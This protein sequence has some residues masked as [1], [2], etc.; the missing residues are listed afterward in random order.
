MRRGSAN[1]Q[2]GIRM[3]STVLLAAATTA[4]WAAEDDA[5]SVVRPVPENFRPNAPS[6]SNWSRGSFT[7]DFPNDII[8][9][10]T[11]FAP[12]P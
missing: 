12:G 3:I 1:S 10:G 6:S 11:G 8:A 2:A 4:A 5:L 9:S 7:P